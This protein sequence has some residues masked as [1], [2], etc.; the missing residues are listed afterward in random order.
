MFLLYLQKIVLEWLQLL[1]VMIFDPKPPN[2][3]KTG[4]IAMV[5]QGRSDKRA[6]H[7]SS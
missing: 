7:L 4:Q 3:V 6:K 2:E 5:A 1:R